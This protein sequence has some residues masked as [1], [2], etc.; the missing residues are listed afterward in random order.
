MLTDI[1]EP[2][3]AAPA[4][5]VVDALQIPA[6][7]CRQT[8]LLVAAGR[9]GRPVNVKKGQWM[10]PEAMAGAV[11]KVRG[12]RQRDVAVTERGTFFG[13]G[14]L[15]VDMR[16]FARLRAA[17]GAPVIFDATHAV[18]Q[19]GTGAA[20]ASGGDRRARTR[21]ARGRGGGRRGWLL[22]RDPSRPGARAERRGHPVAARPAGRAPGSYARPL[23]PGSRPRRPGPAGGMP[24][25]IGSPMQIEPSSRAACACSRSTW[26]ACSPTTASGSARSRASAVELKRFDIQ[27]GLG[28][29]LLRTAGIPVIWL[30]GRHSD[31]TELRARELKVEEVLQVPGPAKLETLVR[32]CSGA[33]SPGRRSPIV[34]DDLADLQ[35][36]RRVGLPLAVANAVAEVRAV[37]HA[38]HP[39]PRRARCGSRGDRGPAQSPGSVARAAGALLHRARD[40]WRVT[41]A[42]WSSW[43]A[44]RSGSRPRASATRRTGST[45]RLPG[46]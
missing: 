9:T 10:P 43:G 39:R 28:L 44:G 18:Q 8:D 14:D 42:R 32:C 30:S 29:V 27:D 33:G 38:T 19:P 4:A 25:M 23:G 21:A 34:G 15:V 1:H 24:R 3:Q 22:S 40:P 5:E 35:V 2:A 31:A 12:G 37:A 6:F 45:R 16:N 11:E 36:L 26:T 20:G 46:R 17:T 41:P 7:L 13:Y